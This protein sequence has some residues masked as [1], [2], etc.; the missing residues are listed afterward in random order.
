MAHQPHPLNAL[1]HWFF[2]APQ[3]PKFKR[4]VPGPAFGG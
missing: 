2:V 3:Y 4:H 1:S